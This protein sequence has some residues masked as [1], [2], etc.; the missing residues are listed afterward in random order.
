VPPFAGFAS[1]DAVLTAVEGRAGW[2]PWA[3]L[4]ATAFLTAFYMGRVL[5]LTFL[6]KPSA[7]AAHAHES[8]AVMTGP[9]LALAIPTVAGGLLGPWLARGMGEEMHLHLGLTPVLASVAALSG[10]TLSFLLYSR[11]RE[12]PLAATIAALDRASIVD[13]TWAFGYRGVLLP[14]SGVLRWV[15]RYLVDGAINGLGWGTLEVGT[16]VR[17][18]QTG[19]TRDYALAVVIGAVVLLVLG[20]WQ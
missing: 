5:V 15:D 1:K 14:L 16:V 10:L 17:P 6:G 19:R 8:P 9:L 3:L 4:L 2:I 18:V 11:G 13:R 7:A 12:A 20:A